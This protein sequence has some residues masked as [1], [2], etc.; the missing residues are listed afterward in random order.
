MH[1][2]TA[3]SRCFN[4]AVGR[5]P[6]REITGGRRVSRYRVS[7]PRLSVRC[8]QR[9]AGPVLAAAFLAVLGGVAAF[10]SAASRRAVASAAVASLGVDSFQV[11]GIEG[12]RAAVVARRA[13]ELRR[14]I[15]AELLGIDEPSEWSPRCTIH[16]H[17]TEESFA[18]AV[19]G[20][21]ISARGAT[22]IE[23][24][25]NDIGMRRIDVM[26]DLLGGL[27]SAEGNGEGLIPDALGHELVHVILADR[28]VDG[29]PP[30]WADEGLAMLFDSPEKQ[31][32]HDEDFRDA[33]IRGLAWSGLDMFEIDLDPADIARERVFYGES[34][35]LVRWF[36]GQGSADTFLCFLEDCDS[37]GLADALDRHYGFTSL[38]EFD[39]RWQ[40]VLTAAR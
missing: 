11:V 13:A 10:P 36:L 35:A 30:R 22:S 19:G 24:V 33:A 18:E 7:T 9:L 27:G 26:G 6:L 3:R 1:S 38:V 34:L 21:P 15:S 2:G 40:A 39:G 16:V 37:S 28:F 17:L 23:F 4:P 32:G 8:V 31:Q 20:A 14:L 12:E 29:P 25:G 5:Y